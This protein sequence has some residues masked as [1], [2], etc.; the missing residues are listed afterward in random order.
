MIPEH[1]DELL[2][3]RLGLIKKKL[4]EKSKEYA[5]TTDRLHNFKAATRVS[6]GNKTPA[7]VLWGLLVKPLI[8]VMDVL[9][10]CK[11]KATLIPLDQAISQWWIDEKIGDLINYLILLEALFTEEL[12]VDKDGTGKLT[13][14]DWTKRAKS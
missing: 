2:E 4:G 6:I 9:E 11:T 14:T 1:F 5:S 7:E 3:R 8:C 10:E 12:Y 13:F